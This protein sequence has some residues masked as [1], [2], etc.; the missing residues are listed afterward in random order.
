MRKIAVEVV[1]ERFGVLRSSEAGEREAVSLAC[2]RAATFQE[3]F[4]KIAAEASATVKTYQVGGDK[5]GTPV[6]AQQY[7]KFVIVRPGGSQNGLLARVG[8]AGLE[9]E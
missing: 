3:Q 2:I 7:A 6:P 9:R 1:D 5:P 8:G 4:A